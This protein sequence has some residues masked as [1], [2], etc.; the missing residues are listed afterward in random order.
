MFGGASKILGHQKKQETTEKPQSPI[1]PTKNL[2]KNKK[3]W[4]DDV[5]KNC[6]PR[7]FLFDPLLP[8]CSGGY[9][10]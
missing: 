10:S 8:T 4:M 9:R 2:D 5:L 1:N 3:N 6:S 7:F